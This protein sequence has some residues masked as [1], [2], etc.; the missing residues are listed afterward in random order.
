M[1]NPV[2]SV[3]LVMLTIVLNTVAQSLLKLGSG[4]HLLNIYLM[5]GLLAYG[6][7]TLAYITVLAKLNLSVIYPVVIGLTIIATTFAGMLLLKESVTSVHWIGI[8]LIISGISAIAFGKVLS[9]T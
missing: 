2:V 3:I 9:I 8:G 5:L 7:S 4:R 6:A 1:E